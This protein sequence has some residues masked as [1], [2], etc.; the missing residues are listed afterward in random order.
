[1]HNSESEAPGIGLPKGPEAGE[2]GRRNVIRQ[3]ELSETN[4]SREASQVLVSFRL[5]DQRQ[6][7]IRCVWQQAKVDGVDQ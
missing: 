3:E 7:L 1:M 6:Q 2:E 5:L 4:G